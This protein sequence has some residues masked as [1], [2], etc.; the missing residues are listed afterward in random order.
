M[1]NTKKDEEKEAR[2]FRSDFISSRWKG[3]GEAR[4]S[5]LTT[6]LN[7]LFVLNSG[8]LAAALAYL[9]TKGDAPIRTSIWIFS[10]GVLVIVLRDRKSTRL[11]SSHVSISYAVFC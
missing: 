4:N 1:P 5:A 2:Q 3:Y 7:Y 8:G 11:N 6:V 9:A 10:F